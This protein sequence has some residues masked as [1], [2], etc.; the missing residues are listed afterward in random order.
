M[1]H[2]CIQPN[3]FKQLLMNGK[4]MLQLQFERYSIEPIK[5]LPSSTDSVRNGA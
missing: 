2:I 1:L 5:F 3:Y 4:K